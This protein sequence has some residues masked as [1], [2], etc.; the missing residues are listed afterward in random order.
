MA[1][2]HLDVVA[3]VEGAL[4]AAEANFTD[5]YNTFGGS[6]NPSVTTLTASGA[7]SGGTVTSTGLETVGSLKVDTGTKTA[8]A[9][10]GAA[11]LN[12]SA[13]VVTSEALTTA[14][15]ATYTR[16]LTNSVV[17]AADQVFASVNLGAGT[18]GTPTIAS[19]T[20]AAGSVVIV[21]QNIH[22][23]AA[24]NAAIKIL[25]HVLKN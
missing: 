1:Q 18:G 3:N 19:V 12:K 17:A 4:R 20:P 13:G 15:G 25:F 8:T 16:T 22:A 5:L 24:F 9:S 7:I 6:A 11:T 23:S 14:A 2:Q 21:V 10:S